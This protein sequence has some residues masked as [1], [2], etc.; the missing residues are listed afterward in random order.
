MRMI[1]KSTYEMYAHRFDRSDRECLLLCA[2]AR[3]ASGCWRPLTLRR[4]ADAIIDLAVSYRFS[5]IACG[6]SDRHYGVEERACHSQDVLVSG[7]FWLQARRQGTLNKPS[8]R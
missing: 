3:S 2:F 7:A 6:F 4:T 1:K 8:P 5:F